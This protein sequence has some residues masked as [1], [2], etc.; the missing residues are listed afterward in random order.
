M[1]NE[2]D[3][4]A[5]VKVRFNEETVTRLSSDSLSAQK[6][7]VANE[8]PSLHSNKN[9]ISIDRNDNSCNTFNNEYDNDSKTNNMIISK[10]KSVKTTR[11]GRKI[12]V[13]LKYSNY[14]ML[15]FGLF[16]LQYVNKTNLNANHYK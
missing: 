16:T 15:L 9:L 10:P 12:H 7:L 1:T 13:P 2:E 6:D 5:K 14:T 4:I 3:R 11:L 8:N